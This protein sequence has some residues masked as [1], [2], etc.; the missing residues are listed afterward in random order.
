MFSPVERLALACKLVYY[1]FQF[2][3]WQFGYF[4]RKQYS[5][6]LAL[7]L[8]IFV[9]LYCYRRNFIYFVRKQYLYLSASRIFSSVVRCRPIQLHAVSFISFGSSSTLCTCL[10]LGR[11]LHTVTRKFSYLVWIKQYLV[12]LPAAWK[13]PPHGYTQ[14]QLSRSDQTVP[15][16]LACRFE[17]T[18][19]RLHANSVISFGSSS[20]LC[21]CLQLGRYLHTVTRKFSYLVRIKQYLVYLPAAW[22][23]PPHGYTQFQLSRLDQAVPCVLAC[24]LDIY[25][26]TV[27]RNFSYL[28]WIKQYLAYCSLDII[29]TSVVCLSNTQFQLSR[30]DQAVPCVQIIWIYLLL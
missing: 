10:Q 14:I 6:L 5:Y 16:V 20:T 27:T 4:V 12:Y 24:S 11:S 30:S 21:T 28:V 15:C 26:H 1:N 2:C 9:A 29:Y 25:L 22:K 19:T 8:Y 7:W 13:I 18:S 3:R 17:D 23:I